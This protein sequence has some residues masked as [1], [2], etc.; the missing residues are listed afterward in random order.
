M[1]DAENNVFDCNQASKLVKLVAVLTKLETLRYPLPTET[2]LLA[3]GVLLRPGQHH[4]GFNSK[5]IELLLGN[6]PALVILD[7]ST[8]G[9]IKA[10]ASCSWKTASSS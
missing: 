10:I 8:V 5:Q 1:V 3:R 2:M 6:T 9:G 7:L 4:S